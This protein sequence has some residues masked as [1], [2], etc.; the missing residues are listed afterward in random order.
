[1]VLNPFL[2]RKVNLFYFS[3]FVIHI[4]IPINVL[5]YVFFITEETGSGFWMFFVKIFRDFYECTLS[6][7]LGYN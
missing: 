7:I 1:M 6:D 4:S 2:V 5:L 3:V